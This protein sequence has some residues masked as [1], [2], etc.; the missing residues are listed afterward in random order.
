MLSRIMYTS[1]R[2]SRISYPIADTA[3]GIGRSGSHCMAAYGRYSIPIAKLPKEKF[4][5]KYSRERADFFRRGRSFENG[6]DYSVRFLQS[7][8]NDSLLFLLVGEFSS[9]S[10]R[11]RS[12]IFL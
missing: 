7:C 4:L 3:S 12:T 6:V 1:V 5:R 10:L 9:T 11:E 8:V 2:Y